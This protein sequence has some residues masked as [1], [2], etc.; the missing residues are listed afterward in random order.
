[1]IL[2]VEDDPIIARHIRAVVKG[3]GHGSVETAADA[4]TALSKALRTPPTIAFLD[5]RLPGGIDGVTVGRELHQKY[6]TTLIFVTGSLDEAVRQM[7]D[8]GVFFIGKPFRDQEIVE[9]LAMATAAE[10]QAADGEP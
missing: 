3:L 1:M 8:P 9:A 5:V 4:E 7:A 10:R 6:R 2:I